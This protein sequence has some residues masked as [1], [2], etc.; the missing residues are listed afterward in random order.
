MHTR[1][2]L[3]RLLGI[4]GSLR[5]AS[6]SR[7]TLRGLRNGLP[8]TMSL[9]IVDLE[10]PLYNQDQDGANAPDTV[11]RLRTAIAESNGVVIVTPE[12]NHGIPGVLKNALDWAS[13]PYGKSVLEKK[14]VLVV[15]VSPAYTGGV[16]AHAQVNETLLSIPACVLGGPQVVIGG[17]AE[18]VRHDALVDRA[19]LDFA[20]AALG[21]L[22]ELSRHVA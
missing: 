3:T 6:F 11:R 12:Y 4:C 22:V 8:A 10:L 16:R 19:S 20:H 2:A 13:R 1:F 14:P 18:K 17:I 5:R 7:A 21:R 9:E 15:S